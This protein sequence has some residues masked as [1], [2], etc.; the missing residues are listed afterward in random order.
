MAVGE[1]GPPYQRLRAHA[2]REHGLVGAASIGSRAG[3]WQTF[4]THGTPGDL[5]ARSSP[6]ARPVNLDP[7]VLPGHGTI[8]D[9]QAFLTDQS[10]WGRP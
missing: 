4:K 10:P 7:D 2:M 3:P 9:I 5:F 8:W 6:Y 1:N